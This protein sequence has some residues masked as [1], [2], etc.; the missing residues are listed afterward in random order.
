[1]KALLYCLAAFLLGA[2]AT[3]GQERDAPRGRTEAEEGVEV[4]TRGP[5]HEAFAG[6]V[7]S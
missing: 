4:L 7:T 3:W 1:M 5:V 2:T 6:T